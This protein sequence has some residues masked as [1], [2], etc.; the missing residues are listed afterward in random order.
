MWYAAFAAC[1]PRL[2]ISARARH[3]HSAC[4]ALVR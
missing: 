2:N 4:F 1:G 3:W